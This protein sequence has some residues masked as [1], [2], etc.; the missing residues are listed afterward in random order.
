LLL[1]P[2]TGRIV[3]ARGPR[4]PL[5]VAGIATTAG[6][7]MLTRLTRDSSVGY[8]MACYVVLG[9]GCGTV[10]APIT[11]TAMSGMPRSQAGVAAGIAS[12]SRQVGSTLGVAVLGA[13]VLSSLHGSL[14]LGFVDAS[15]VGWWIIAGCGVVILLVGLAT[16]G[17]WAR[18]T[19]ERTAATLMP[20]NPRV[21]VSTPSS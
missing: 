10:N 3:A 1:A 16:S 12:T 2:V 9:I 15:R 18:R 8:L 11:N 5:I 17:R 7:I 19:A 20:S 21:P 13:T 4:L 6:G 14:R